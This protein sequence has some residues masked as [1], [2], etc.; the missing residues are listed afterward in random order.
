MRCHREYRCESFFQI[1]EFS[2]KLWPLNWNRPLKCRHHRGTQDR[3][4]VSRQLFFFVDPTTGK[5]PYSW[6]HVR[7]KTL[8]IRTIH[9]REWRRH[10]KKKNRQQSSTIRSCRRNTPRFEQWYSST[11]V[12]LPIPWSKYCVYQ[13]RWTCVYRQ[14]TWHEQC[15]TRCTVSPTTRH[16]GGGIAVQVT[17]SLNIGYTQNWKL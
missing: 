11:C 4:T 7:S 1:R 5:S 15:S 13:S 14:T 8:G 6:T 2:Q 16:G 3:P 10:K 12:C 17:C 9:K